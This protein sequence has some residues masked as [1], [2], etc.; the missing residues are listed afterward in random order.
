[1]RSAYF[2]SP[3]ANSSRQLNITDATVKVHL[4]GVLK[5]INAAKR[6]AKHGLSFLRARVFAQDY[7][8]THP[9]VRVFF[10]NPKERWAGFLSPEPR[11]GSIEFDQ[12]GNP[13]HY[14]PQEVD[15]QGR[16]LASVKDRLEQRLA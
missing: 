3:V 1:M 10:D 6:A 16:A 11:V 5:K 9:G 7:A 12:N 15:S 2:G 8:R 14:E 4:K 13:A